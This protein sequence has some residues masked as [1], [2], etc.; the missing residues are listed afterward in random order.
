VR[1]TQTLLV[2]ALAD[3]ATGK[4]VETIT[5]TPEHPFHVVGKGFTAAINLALGNAIVT[6]AGPPLLV[7]SIT[8]Q[9]HP[10]GVL[11]YNFEVEDDH[12]YFVGT[13]NGGTW[14][15]N[16]C[17]EA[18]AKIFS[19]YPRSSFSC[20]KAAEEALAVLQTEDPAAYIVNITNKGGGDF[21]RTAQG[22]RIASTG[23]HRAVVS[24]GRYF[25]TMTGAKGATLDEYE[26]LFHTEH[27]GYLNY[28]RH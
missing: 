24:K 27:H 26:K 10:E 19:R 21:M 28:D 5:T 3:R 2:L 17:T 20:D 1:T 15:H 6:R 14:V 16:D 13:V 25:D 7:Q 22:Q 4:V 8:P 12:T 9:A 11:V 23:F 18:L